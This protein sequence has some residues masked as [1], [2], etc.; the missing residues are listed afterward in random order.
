MPDTEIAKVA[1]KAQILRVRSP[2]RLV[3]TNLTLLQEE[4]ASLDAMLANMEKNPR[5][6]REF[7]DGSGRVPPLI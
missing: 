7:P 3:N 6:K 1:E 5:V 2:P 4:L